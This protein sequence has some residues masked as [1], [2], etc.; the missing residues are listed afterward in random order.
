MSFI[1]LKKIIAVLVWLL[2][3]VYGFWLIMT[4]QQMVGLNLLFVEVAP[5]NSGL[6]VVL[7]FM[8]GCVLGLFAAVFVWRVIP[9]RWQLRQTHKELATLRKQ[10]IK[11]PVD[12]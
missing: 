11:P 5:L 4:N 8:L 9:L 12:S 10:Y 1:R 6:L 7:S 3:M 2:L